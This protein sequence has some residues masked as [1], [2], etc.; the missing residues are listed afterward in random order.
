MRTIHYFIKITKYTSFNIKKFSTR[1]LDPWNA[2][3]GCCKL[4]AFIPDHWMQKRAINIKFALR[5][6]N[7][8]F[9][10][11]SFICSFHIN[12]I[13]YSNNNSYLFL[14][15]CH[16]LFRSEWFQLPNYMHLIGCISCCFLY[17]TFAIRA[18]IALYCCISI[19]FFIM[20]LNVENFIAKINSGHLNWLI[21]GV[22][23]CIHLLCEDSEMRLAT[24][25]QFLVIH[26]VHIDNI[27]IYKINCIY[28][29]E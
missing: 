10:H 5:Q 29:C 27:F 19:S 2:L 14:N 13:I 26:L 3:E 17:G 25:Y 16:S 1:K 20:T 12:K 21:N 22:R 11:V 23:E 24:R 4:V 6:Q 18:N 28:R 15:C 9:I 7:V 8:I